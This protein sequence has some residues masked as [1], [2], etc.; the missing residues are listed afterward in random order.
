MHSQRMRKFVVIAAIAGATGVAAGA[1]G[2]HA[3]KEI[4]TERNSVST[5]NT[6]LL[7]HLI[8]SV[9]LLSIALHQTDKGQPPSGWFTKSLVCWTTGI[10][11]FSGSLYGLALGGP[12]L[13]GPITPLGGLFFILGWVFVGLGASKS[14]PNPKS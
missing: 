12:K 5:W 13:L 11:L 9:T 2:A 6:A 10:L 14:Q 3:L 7:Y 8:H 4:L 1:Y